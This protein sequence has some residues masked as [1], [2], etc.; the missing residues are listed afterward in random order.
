LINYSNLVDSL[1]KKKTI[2]YDLF[3]YYGSFNNVYGPNLVDL[4]TLLSEEHLNMYDSGVIRNSCT[5][6]NKIIGM[7][8][9]Y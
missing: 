8:N 6:E 7:V 4:K 1:L 5:Y 3:F 2:K 9:I